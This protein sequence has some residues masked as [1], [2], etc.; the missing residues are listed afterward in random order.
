[1][2]PITNFIFQ[3]TGVFIVWVFKFQ[4]ELVGNK[5]TYKDLTTPAFHATPPC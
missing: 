1:M 5:Q 4:E 3:I 2:Y